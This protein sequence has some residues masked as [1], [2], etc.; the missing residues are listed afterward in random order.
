M[1]PELPMLPHDAELEALWRRFHAS[2]VS[3]SDHLAE[4]EQR[5]RE[6]LERASLGDGERPA[7]VEVGM[8]EVLRAQSR[9]QRELLD[10]FE[11]QVHRFRNRTAAYHPR[12]V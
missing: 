2:W 4:C 6:A 1:R 9:W 12:Y 10:R 8:L 3:S 11:R 5:V 7:P